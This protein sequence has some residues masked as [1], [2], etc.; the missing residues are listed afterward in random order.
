MKQYKLSLEIT[1]S[2]SLLKVEFSDV[3]KKEAIVDLL[4]DFNIV[5]IV[6]ENYVSITCDIDLSEMSIGDAG[7]VMLDV[8]Y[9]LI[10]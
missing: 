9:L 7:V 10:T 6:E 1:D 8:E 2:I 4:K 5:I 3:S